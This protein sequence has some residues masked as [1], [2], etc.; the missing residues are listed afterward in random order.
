MTPYICPVCGYPELDK[1]AYSKGAP[2]FEIC[3][4]CGYQFGYDDD[5]QNITHEKWRE[6]WIREGMVWWSR[7]IKPTNWNPKA[8]LQ[9]IGVNSE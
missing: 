1:A 6:K 8:Q 4:C 2:S 3:P 9:S 7:N 5:D